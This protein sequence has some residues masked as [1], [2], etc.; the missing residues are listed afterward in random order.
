M[1]DIVGVGLIL[2]LVLV[3]GFFVAAEFAIVKVRGT[4]ITELAHEGKK[5]ARVADHIVSHLD[6]YLSATQLGITMASL[7]LGWIGEPALAHLMEAPLR[8]IG[9]DGTQ[10]RLVGAGIIS[11]AV[12]TFLH[13]VLG[14]LAPKSLAIRKSEG[15]ALVIAL[16][17]RAFFLVFKPVI[18]LFNGAA[19]LVLRVFDVKPATEAE[20]AHS[21]EELRMILTASQEVGHI[22]E[23]EQALMR[24]ALTFGDRAVG[25]IMVPRT[26]MAALSADMPIAEALEEVASSNHTRYPVYEED[27]DDTIGYVHVK[28]LYRADPMRQVRSLIRPVGFISETANIEIALKRFQTTRTPLAI[29]VDEHGGTG[30]I[31]TIQDVIEELIGEMQDEFDHEAPEVESLEEGGFSVDGGARID[32]LKDIIHL[33]VPEEGFPTLGGRVFE[34]LQRR[35]RVDDEVDVGNFHA[36]ILEVEGMRI[37]RVQMTALEP[38]RMPGETLD[39]EEDE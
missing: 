9:I 5:R 25:D 15:T 8:W 29:V 39:Q 2:V 34:Q 32:Y 12:I 19:N 17:L 6:A 13:I 10:A 4:R 36:R 18:W 16:P 20:L 22:D 21:E 23:V 35:P 38:V 26:E 14:E 11:F 30:G 27:V 28:D 37:V 24:R 7:G 1:N 31:V 3:N 33:E